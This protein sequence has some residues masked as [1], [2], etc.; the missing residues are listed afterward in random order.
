MNKHGRI[1]TTTSGLC[2]R[3]SD[4]AWKD[5]FK[6]TLD[7][8]WMANWE[9]LSIADVPVHPVAELFMVAIGCILVVGAAGAVKD[10]AATL[11][12]VQRYESLASL[13]SR[14]RSRTR[15]DLG[16]SPYSK[17][18]ML[19]HWLFHPE[20]NMFI[21]SPRWMTAEERRR[22][23]SATLRPYIYHALWQLGWF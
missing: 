18:C 15:Q 4:L 16:P 6:R 22:R 17:L 21:P 10:V 7:G 13:A 2:G 8:K 5:N 3:T 1:G 9:M 19:Y 12:S 23:Y 11:I 14:E 20:L